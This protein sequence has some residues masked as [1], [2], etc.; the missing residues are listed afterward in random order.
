MHGLL[1][2]FPTVAAALIALTALSGC[3]TGVE[4]TPYIKDTAP[5]A[6]AA[7]VSAEEQL[8]SAVRPQEPAKWG[9]GKMFLVTPGRWD[10]AYSPASA[11]RQ[12]AVGDTLYFKEFRGGIRL[13]GDSIAEAVLTSSSQREIVY[14]LEIPMSQALKT[15]TLQLPF[16]VDLDMVEQARSILQ[17]RKVWTLKPDFQGR[18]FKP[19]TI[20]QVLAGSADYPFLVIADTDTIQMVTNSAAATARTFA[21]LFS[22]KDPR[23]LHPDV[24]DKNWELICR[25]KLAID[26]TREEARLSLGYPAQIDR[27][28]APVGLLERWTYEDGKILNFTDGLLTSFRI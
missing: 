24:S 14:R 6:A 3:F 19:L 27:Q 17:G 9:R 7:K 8:V 13:S 21:N 28:A 23:K 10:Y 5:K 11:A 22:L 2:R 16:T 4:K 12:L 25:G 15:K 1:K 18:R 20:N 26:M